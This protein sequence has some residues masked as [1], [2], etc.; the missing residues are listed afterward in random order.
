MK[1]SEFGSTMFPSRQVFTA[2]CVRGL[3]EVRPLQSSAAGDDPWGWNFG[4]ATPP[5]YWA[6][7]RLRALLTLAQAKRLKPKRVLEVAAGDAALSACLQQM[8]CEVVANDL[9]SEN[10]EK[11]VASF[12]NRNSIRLVAGDVFE[13][14]PTDL[15]TFDLVIACELIEHVA[16]APALIKQLKRFLAPGGHILMTTPNGSH[17]RNRLPTYSQI[18][19][20]E[21]LEAKQFKPDAD[22]HLYLITA[23]ELAHIANEA[24][25]EIKCKLLW[26]TPF[27]YGDCGFRHISRMLPRQ[28]WYSLELQCQRFG[29]R[30][31]NRFATS[32][33]VVLGIRT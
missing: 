7:G 20:F 11:S 18:H 12:T 16:H 26:G 2:V 17:F 6:Y 21:E 19:N 24:G 14:C 33:S 8:G 4:K 9:R 27:I 10:L 22:G 13:L 30:F 28:W 5:S 25:L 23:E 3:S 29:Q 31:L 32:I 1:E 15:G